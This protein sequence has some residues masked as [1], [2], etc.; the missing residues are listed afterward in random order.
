VIDLVHLS[1]TAHCVEVS[2]SP[3]KFSLFFWRYETFVLLFNKVTELEL[4]FQLF[5][6][7]VVL[8]ILFLLH[9]EQF[10]HLRFGKALLQKLF[11]VRDSPQNVVCVHLN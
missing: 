1:A 10:I 7:L 6:E 3:V 2:Q 5:L 8:G 9:A 11:A 4:T